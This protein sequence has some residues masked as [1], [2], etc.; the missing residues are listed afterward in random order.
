M[1]V[2]CNFFADALLV[3]PCCHRYDVLAGFETAGG[4][5]IGAYDEVLLG[6]A[7]GVRC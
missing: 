1:R 6:E 4:V 5:S 3:Q 2:S 7:D